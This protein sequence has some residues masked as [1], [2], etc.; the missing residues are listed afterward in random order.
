MFLIDFF[1]TIEAFFVSFS[2]VSL[3]GFLV[4]HLKGS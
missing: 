2:F 4:I 3:I 1:D